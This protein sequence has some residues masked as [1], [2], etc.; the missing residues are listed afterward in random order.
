MEAHEIAAQMAVHQIAPSVQTMQTQFRM[1]LVKHWGISS[2]AR[3]LEIGCG[4]GDMTAVLAAA[5]GAGGHVIAVDIADPSYGAPITLGDSAAALMRSPLGSRITFQFQYDVLDPAHSFDADAFDYV[6][7]AHCSWYFENLGQI[8]RTLE[9]VHPWSRRLCFSEWDM[10]P[11]S[12]DQTAHLLSVL[13][14]GQIEAHRTG[15]D[16]NVRTPFSKA[17]LH[18]ML[19]AA[20]WEALSESTVDSGG[21]QDARWEIDNCLH[22]YAT[23]ID[24]PSL[25]SKILDLLGSQ[26]DVLKSLAVSGPYRSLPSYAITAG[27]HEAV[28]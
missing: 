12:F 14:Q 8:R 21:L 15:S 5:V 23:E 16:A 10:A 13:I 17:K 11:Q 27:R 19:R 22:T 18:K 26:V 20:G 4:Q 2:G 24:T 1:E 9:R 3:V 25:P 6:V 7:M 28:G